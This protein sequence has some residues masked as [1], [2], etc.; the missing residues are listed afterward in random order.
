[1]KIGI[2]TWFKAINHGA[3]LQAYASQNYINQMGY[4]SII[5]D[6]ERKVVN[7]KPHSEQIKQK[8][9]KFLNGDFKYKKIYKK[10]NADK[11]TKFDEFIRENINLGKN[12]LNERCNAVM[13]GSD[14]VFNLL[15]GYSPYMFGKG[16]QTKYIFSYAASAGGS[17]ISVANR[18]GLVKEIENGLKTFYGIGCRDQETKAFVRDISGRTDMVDTIDPVLL[19]GF[20]DEK[21]SWNS[22]KWKKHEPYVLLYA[23]NGCMNEKKER[24]Q[25]LR[26][27]ADNNLMVIS[28]G[29]YHPWCDENVNADPKEFVE[30]FTEATCIITDTFHGTVFSLI[31]EKNFC[32]IIRGNSFKLK[33]L[34]EQCGLE[35]NIAQTPE[36]I[37]EILSNK[38]DY[39]NFNSWIIEQRNKS[40]EYLRQ[41]LYNAESQNT[42]IRN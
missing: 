16:L 12:C 24:K 34:L 36:H 41:Q 27:A 32:S 2:L 38:T 11:R 22:G 9:K 30:M 4:T 40:E 29:Y 39:R 23:Y 8:L 18:M 13:I 33:Y 15:Q 10:F 5:L 28:C 14:M 1:M 6:Y 20:K 31:N 19:Y 17:T 26:F 35:D 42:K 25:I 21:I 3:I 7:M 37:Y